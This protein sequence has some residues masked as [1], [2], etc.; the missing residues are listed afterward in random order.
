[1]EGVGLESAL[2]AVVMKITGI[3]P[4]N[5]YANFGGNTK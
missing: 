4:S 2:D 1:M 3:R 5:D